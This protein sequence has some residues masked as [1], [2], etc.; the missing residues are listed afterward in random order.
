M[1]TSKDILHQGLQH[2]CRLQRTTT[3]VCLIRLLIVFQAHNR[4]ISGCMWVVISCLEVCPGSWI[5]WMLKSHPFLRSTLMALFPRRSMYT[6]NSNLKICNHTRS[7]TKGLLQI[8][9]WS[10]LMVIGDNTQ[11]SLG[12]TC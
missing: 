10:M 2:W 3:S 8:N 12:G 5:L 1:K 7:V 4:N 9:C 6:K 11:I